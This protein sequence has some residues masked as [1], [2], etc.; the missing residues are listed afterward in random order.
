VSQSLNIQI[1][2]K[3]TTREELKVV[4]IHPNMRSIR[5]S[6]DP[7][8]FNM[9]AY[10]AKLIRNKFNHLAYSPSILSDKDRADNIRMFLL[11]SQKDQLNGTV[12]VSDHYP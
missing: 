8:L 2:P 10:E 6:S 5:I 1:S 12:R 3:F 7:E 11:S 9:D 4:K